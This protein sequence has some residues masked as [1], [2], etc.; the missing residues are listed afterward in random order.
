MDGSPSA[1]ITGGLGNGTFAPEVGL[2]L[3]LGLGMGEAA[4]SGFLCG[5]ISV[6]PRLAGTIEAKPRLSGEVKVNPC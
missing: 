2:L 4:E 6:R 1:L 5:R 3:T